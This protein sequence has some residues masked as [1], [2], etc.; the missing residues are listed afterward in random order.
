[1]ILIIAWLLFAVL[2]GAFAS[3]RGRSGFAF[4]LLS[5]ILSPVVGFII[6]LVLGTNGPATAAALALPGASADFRAKWPDLARY[7]PDISRAVDHLTQYGNEAVLRFRD[8]YGAVADKAA[9]PTIIADIEAKAR[10]ITDPSGW[11][12]DGFQ[13][14]GTAHGLQLF[15]SGN[16]YWVAGEHLSNIDAAMAFASQLAQARRS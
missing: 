4:F 12:P 9:I 11:A 5:V 15:K 6:A 1:M 7:D 2:V 10:S 3:G 16:T 14:A 8:A 13:K